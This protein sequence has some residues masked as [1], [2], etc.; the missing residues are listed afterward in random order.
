VSTPAPSAESGAFQE[1]TALSWQRTGLSLL[2]GSM[3]ML[4]LSVRGGWFTVTLIVAGG[5]L[6][7]VAALESR[8]RARRS[9]AVGEGVARVALLMAAALTLLL[10][11][12]LELALAG[13]G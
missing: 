2:G 9:T 1:R 3:V 13:R 10:M 12:E 7:G 4:R 5:L 6:A 11:A 8:R